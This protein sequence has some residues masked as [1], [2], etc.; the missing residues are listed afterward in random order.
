M[1]RFAAYVRADEH[2]SIH[3]FHLAIVHVVL[4][5]EYPKTQSPLLLHALN[6]KT[7]KL[8]YTRPSCADVSTKRLF[9]LNVYWQVYLLLLKG[10]S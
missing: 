4:E 7:I 9:P 8:Y 6:G 1:L 10:F 3:C 5:T 2:L